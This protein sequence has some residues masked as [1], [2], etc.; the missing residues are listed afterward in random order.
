MNG[1]KRIACFFTAGY[2]ELNSMKLFVKKV[3]RQL[4]YIQLCPTGP[5]KSKDQIKRR[6]IDNV[7]SKYNGLTGKN[8]I[9]HVLSFI[10]TKRF[11]EESYD[12]ILIEDDKD[13]RFL[14][15]QPD[16]SASF[17]VGEWDN[18]RQNVKNK[19]H[20]IYPDL[21]VIFLFAAPEVESWFLSDW[22]NSFGAVYKDLLT[23]NQNS[24]FSFQFRKYVNAHILTQRYFH[25]IEEYGY[26][27]GVYKKLS[28]EI[29]DALEK[30]DF[31]KGYLPAAEHKPIRYSKKIQG[32]RM[33]EAI[34][35]RIV[36]DKC[37]TF[38]KKGLFDLQFLL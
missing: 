13:D 27:N 16:G 23:A 28:K 18:F 5:R 8:L 34:D 22:D 9:D 11:R 1:R 24:Y 10:E 31:L 6:H 35:P 3:N 29:Q 14:S 38:F 33:L 2:T 19:V 32:E 4:D 20:R 37:P 36:Q 15:V 12:A 26:F 30:N 21:P 7:D 25:S 17:D